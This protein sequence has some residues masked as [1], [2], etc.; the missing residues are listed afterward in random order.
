MPGL[1]STTEEIEAFIAECSERLK[2]P[3]DNVERAWTVADRR[4]ARDEIARRARAKLTRAELAA[5]GLKL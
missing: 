4:E 3:M 1:H 5:L 2:G